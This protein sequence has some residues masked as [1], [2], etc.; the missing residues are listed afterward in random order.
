MLNEKGIREKAWAII[1]ENREL[2]VREQEE[3]IVKAIE[4]TVEWVLKSCSTRDE[5]PM[6]WDA[7]FPESKANALL[8]W[9]EKESVGE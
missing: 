3:R 8:A 7:G 9:M 5:W 4:F 1:N 2:K 6:T